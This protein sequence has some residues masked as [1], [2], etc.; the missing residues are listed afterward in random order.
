MEIRP[1]STPDPPTGLEATRGDGEVTLSWATDVKDTVDDRYDYDYRQRRE[2][3]IYGRWTDFAGVEFRSTTDGDDVTSNIVTG[4]TNGGTYAFQ[5]RAVATTGGISRIRIMDAES[6]PSDEV[7]VSLSGTVE[8]GG[9][10]VP[11]NFDA[12]AGDREVTLSWTAPAADGGAAIIGYEYQLRAGAGA[13]GEWTTIPG[14][15]PSRSYIVTGLT[16]ETRY[17]F[18]V[19][20]VNSDGAGPGSTEESATPSLTVDTTLRAL[21]LSTVTL[22]PV[23]LAPAF[24][25][26][27]RTY[28]ARRRQQRDAGDGDGDAEQGGRDGDDHAGRREHRRG[29]SPGGPGGRSQPIR[30]RVTDGT[31]AGDYTITVTRAASVPAA[32]T[33]LTATADEDGGGAVTLSWTAPTGGGA[34]SRYEYRQKAGT[35]AYGAWT[36]IPNSGA[37]TTSHTVPGLTRR[38]GLHLQ[39]PCRE[40]RG[41]RRGVDRGHRHADHGEARL[42]EVGAG[43][44]RRDRPCEGR[45]RRRHGLRRGRGDRDPGERPVRRGPGRHALYEAESSNSDVASVDDT[46]TVRVTVMAKAGGM[47]DITIT[48]N[49]SLPSGLTINPQTDPREARHHVPGRGGHRGARA[50]AGRPTNTNL[51][52]GGRDHANGTAGRATVTV[53][54]NR[55]VT[56]EVT[57][58][59]LADR[60]MGD[61]TAADFE[62]DPIVLAAGATTGSTEVTAVDDGTAEDREALVLFGMAG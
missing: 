41:R 48:A 58:T 25:P 27:T 49:A 11:R 56:R 33:G 26:A 37:S 17:Y 6:D 46:D 38:H 2:R 20:A 60:A 29:R 1:G 36:S 42:G 23:T 35:G 21:S 28:T 7:T 43:C 62:A 34:V 3:G 19:R 55:P 30:V 40:Q 24:T 5:V 13:Y 10:S 12:A 61:A 47:A 59:L 4:L 45:V 15:G 44:R 18:R 54:A 16:N 52:E 14:G 51:V 9:L 53:Q 31:N 57:V 22:A 50:R 39:G 8:T 32:P